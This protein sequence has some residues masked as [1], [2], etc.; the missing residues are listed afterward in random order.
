[1]RPSVTDHLKLTVC[2]YVVPNTNA[3]FIYESEFL[4][5]C[6]RPPITFWYPRN[7]PFRLNAEAVRSSWL[8]GNV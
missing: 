2:W 7:V 6:S 3:A 1:M 5:S 4:Q 8:L